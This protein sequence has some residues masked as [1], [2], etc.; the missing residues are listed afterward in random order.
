M[1]YFR[2]T[3][4]KKCKTLWYEAVSFALKFPFSKDVSQ[5]C[6]VF[7]VV[8]VNIEELSLAEF[9][10]FGGVNFNFSG[11]LAKLLLRFGPVNFHF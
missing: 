2:E 3:A 5:N 1:Q 4:S 11:R 7:D 8:N 9:C 10:R 6:F